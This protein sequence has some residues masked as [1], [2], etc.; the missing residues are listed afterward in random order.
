MNVPYY[1]TI[2]KGLVHFGSEVRKISY[3]LSVSTSTFQSG[4][5][6]SHSALY[7]EYGA[8]GAVAPSLTSWSG[9]FKLHMN[10]AN[11][12]HVQWFQP[13]HHSTRRLQSWHDMDATS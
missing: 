4:G 2:K 13:V 1:L 5:Y 3:T 8:T 12:H 10:L 6:S 7:S 9:N 11:H